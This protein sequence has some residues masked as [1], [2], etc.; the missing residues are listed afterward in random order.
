[1]ILKVLP[2]ISAWKLETNCYIIQDEETKETMIIDPGGEPEKIL[3]L[4]NVLQANVKYIYLTH[5]HI[6]HTRATNAIKEKTGGKI[7]ISVEDAKNINNPEVNASTYLGIEEQHIEVDARV[8]D[9]DILHLGELEFKVI[10]TPG[11]TSGCS[12]LY[13]ENKKML[14]S[15][16]TIF[17][18]TWGRTDLVTS[19]FNDI[20]KSISNKLLTLPDDTI[21][22]SGHGEVTTIKEEEPIY[23][24][25]QP[26]EE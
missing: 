18:G 26:S 19:S 22:Y 23:Y 13:C 10:T 14:F 16:D 15:G 12:C 5:C 21:V 8:N 2:V 17:K 9:G 11:H 24:N 7:L 25:L 3:E 20:I 6:D 4:L 1:M